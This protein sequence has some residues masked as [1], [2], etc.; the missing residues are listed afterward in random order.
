MITKIPTNTGNTS[1]FSMN[2]CTYGLSLFA[3]NVD[4]AITPI[5]SDRY[6]FGA[7]LLTNAL[8]SGEKHIS[9]MVITA[10]NRIGQ[11]TLALTDASAP[12]PRNNSHNTITP[13]ASPTNRNPR[14]T[15][16]NIFISPCGRSASFF[17][18]AAII[19]PRATHRSPFHVVVIHD[20]AISNEP[21]LIFT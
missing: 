15:F 20:G 7:Y 8:R 9:P 18:I 21:R 14:P 2:A 6:F 19:P 13:N 11:S 3:T 5:S 10:E 17:Q 4:T 16:L 12:T 1:N